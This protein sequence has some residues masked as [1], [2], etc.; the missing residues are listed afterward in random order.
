[1]SSIKVPR[2]LYLIILKAIVYYHH[3]GYGF[4]NYLAFILPAEPELF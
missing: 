2:Y 1:M 3:I 4:T